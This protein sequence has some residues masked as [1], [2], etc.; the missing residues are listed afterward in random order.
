[1]QGKQISTGPV[2]LIIL[3]NLSISGYGMPLA[4]QQ[5]SGRPPDDPSEPVGCLIVGLRFKSRPLGSKRKQVDAGERAIIT[6]LALETY[7]RYPFKNKF[8]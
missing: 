1:M 5:D 4:E 8:T 3:I 6:A 7:R 2:H